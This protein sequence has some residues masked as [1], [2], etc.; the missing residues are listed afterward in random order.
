MNYIKTSN[1][2]IGQIENTDL[3]AS[4]ENLL[5]NFGIGIGK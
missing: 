3:Y 4:D 5:D 2:M 1:K